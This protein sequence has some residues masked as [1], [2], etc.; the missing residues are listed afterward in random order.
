[1]STEWNTAA[2]MALPEDCVGSSDIFPVVAREPI[3]PPHLLALPRHP[4]PSQSLHDTSGPAP[5]RFPEEQVR[6]WVEEYAGHA[7]RHGTAHSMRLWRDCFHEALRELAR[8]ALRQPEDARC[9]SLHWKL[10]DGE[11]LV[12]A[13]FESPLAATLH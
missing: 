7:R 6:R 13:R 5:L 8:Q 11:Y 9:A 12:A 10:L 4:T 3:T 2:W 1:M